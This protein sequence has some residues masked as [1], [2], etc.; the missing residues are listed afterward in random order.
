MPST[1]LK[2]LFAG[3]GIGGGGGALTPE[4]V[5]DDFTAEAGGFYACDT[6]EQSF[7]ATLDGEIGDLVTLEDPAGTWGINA[8]TV[9]GGEDLTIDGQESKAFN[10]PARVVLVRVAEGWQVRELPVLLFPFR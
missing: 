7:S 9:Q 4:L 2:A 6:T 8:L 10:T 5:T 1:T 3:R